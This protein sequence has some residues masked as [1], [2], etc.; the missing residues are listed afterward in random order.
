VVNW[1]QFAH[2]KTACSELVRGFILS[3]IVADADSGEVSPSS[4]TAELID[5]GPGTD[6]QDIAASDEKQGARHRP[7]VRGAW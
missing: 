7:P 5:R 4:P 6:F 2:E 1:P 3:P